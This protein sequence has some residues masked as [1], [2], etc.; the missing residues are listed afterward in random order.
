MKR[1]ASNHEPPKVA[2][3]S[4]VHSVVISAEDSERGQE[5]ET[6]DVSQNRD[7]M[8]QIAASLASHSQDAGYRPTNECIDEINGA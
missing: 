2:R 7:L 8:R 5:Q 4:G 6:L 3:H 1:V